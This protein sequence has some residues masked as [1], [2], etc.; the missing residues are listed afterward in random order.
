MQPICL[1]DFTIKLLNHDYL[2]F[3]TRHML[4]PDNNNFINENYFSVKVL[5]TNEEIRNNN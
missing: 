4:G 2:N 5:D 3:S 1:Y